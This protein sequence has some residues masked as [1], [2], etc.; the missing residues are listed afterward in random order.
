MQFDLIKE[1]LT[2]SITGYITNSIAI[3]MIFREY[4][5]GKL[6]LGGVI[7]KTREEFI[8]NI[9]SLVERD[10]INPETLKEELSKESFKNG[11]DNFV[12]DL[13]NTCIYENTS[14]LK[15]KDLNGFD[16]TIDKTQDYMKNCIEQ[17]LPSV[18]DNICKNIYLKDILNEKQGQYISEQLFKSVSHI[19]DNSDFVEKTTKDFY[20]ENK[21]INFGEF[22]ENKLLDVISSNLEDILKDLHLDLK[23]NFDK[24]I[25][26]VFENTLETLEIN[27]ILSSLEEKLLEKRIIDFADNTD[28]LSLSKSLIGKIKDF[29]LSDDGK[30]LINNFS[31]EL[32]NL[33]KNIDKPVLELLSDDLKDNVENFFKDK[34]Q[35][36]IKEIILWIEK[37]KEDIEGLIEKAI[38]DTISSVDDGMKKNMLN[39][40]RDKFLTDVAKKFDIVSKITDYLEQNADIDSISK[41]ITLIIINYLK[42]EKISDIIYKLEK[43]KVFTAESLGNAIN[44]NISN[45]ID[46]IPED[47]FCGLLNKKIK[48]I[49]SLNLV[50]LFQAHIKGP[51]ISSLKDNYIY[52]EKATKII[53]EELVKNIKNINTLNLSE[54]IS[55]E[56][57]SSNYDAIKKSV[58]KKLHSNE[59][60]I[61]KS[62]S[63]EL[64]K[65]IDSLSLY[66][67][68]KDDI[69][70]TLLDE[71]IGE[72]SNKIA[73]LLESSKDIDLKLLWDTINSTDN[74]KSEATNFTLSTLEENLPYILNGNIKKAVS[75]NLRDLKDEELQTMV[76]EF[77]GKE[78]KPITVIG[79]LLGAIVGIGMYFFDNSV[80]QYN[81]L[82]ATLISV[83][84]YAFVGWLTNVQA[85]E[86]LFKPYY[87]KRLFGIKIPFTP[88]VIVSRKPKFAKSMST[89]VDEELLKKNS[90]EELFNKNVGI[91]HN[92]IKDTISKDN[93]KLV[94]DFLNSHSEVIGDK[95]F[96][97]LK[98]SV[99]TNKYSI[100]SSLCKKTEALNLNKVDFS[101]TKNKL[102]EAILLRIK[103]SN[104]SIYAV[105]DNLLKKD[106]KVFE[107]MPENFKALLKKQI[108]NKVE[109]EI[110]NVVSGI[111][112]KD[113]INELLLMLSTKYET[114]ENKS[115]RELLSQDDIS[116]YQEY[117][118]NIISSKIT[119]EE[120]RT[121]LLNWI[122]NIVSRETSNDKKLG[123]LF[124]GFFI[125]IIESNFSYIMD[126]TVKSILTGLTNN[127][128]VISEVAITTTKESL[129]FIELM[130][131]NMLGG[132][133]IVASVIDNLINDK[134]PTY[135]EGK[136]AELNTILE[137]F[138]NNKICNSTVSSLN[139]SLQNGQVLEVINKFINDEENVQRLD[140][141]TLKITDSLF[142]W[143]TDVKLGECFSILS[144]NKIEDLINIFEN[145]I[146]FT[147]EQLENS[148][149]E[150][151]ETLSIEYIKLIFS[152]FEGLILSNKVSA[153]TS[154]INQAYVET[155]SD[156]LSTLIYDSNSIKNGTSEFTN[157]LD[158]EL[159]GKRL[160]D[161]LDLNEL[162]RCVFCTIEKVLENA[163]LNRDTKSVVE[164]ILKDIIEK[165]L[166][167]VDNYTKDAVVKIILTSVLDS[168]SRNFSN[169]IST[170]DFR[171]IT[172][173]QINAMNPR[174]I[175]ELFN[176]FAK[177]YF[178]KL[179]LY[180]LGGA[181]F[182]LHWIVGVV[183]FILYAGNGIKNKMKK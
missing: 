20:D 24:D 95:S 156:K 27:K 175:E 115:V 136:K 142:N 89:F 8:N 143:I 22:F 68:L 163:D 16:S 52:T 131:Y 72:V 168:A 82:T 9:S 140:H 108:A 101:K 155:L 104:K 173:N 74:I 154:G 179:K 167:I 6:K 53:T 11:I 146:S 180:G 1:V 172:E 160:E 83:A 152:V 119:S 73:K 48:D 99:H 86:M 30:K 79:A 29:A 26:I 65:S 88:G 41:D 56:D 40:V 124:G 90:M 158:K 162:N 54:L 85:L 122:E 137:N 67:S 76:E 64:E 96:N 103:N 12:D 33:L 92:S 39:L 120:T 161:L 38:D 17:Q 70:D 43:N 123:E 97:Y 66:D 13:L 7:I 105:L 110:N 129:N 159:K 128:Q 141:I 28:N 46:Y 116:K 135:I 21:A 62:I 127:Q 125:K 106:D 126:N 147:V 94:V 35:Y 165:N 5:I 133:D 138:I 32:H 23:N 58:V 170:I 113:K 44:Y 153:F 51:I 80:T 4:G 182:G 151:R 2:G 36:A 63:T 157:R 111:N 87:E 169:I 177:K 60:N 112:K 148:I 31:K 34:L 181:V 166:N 61:I 71:S 59:S 69:R 164:S 57:L 84:V 81:Y 144:I 117:M 149:V 171:G 49:F 75:S 150:K 118:N 139:L 178:N 18:F 183:T 91:I 176:S 25:D 3:K 55:D 15:L 134:F 114:I 174:E 19:L 37:N 77:M 10:I 78:M 50:K 47:Y 109:K 14:N 102:E 42:E 132:D 130:G 93:Y 45:Y 145:E 107:V 98:N 100:A 121:K